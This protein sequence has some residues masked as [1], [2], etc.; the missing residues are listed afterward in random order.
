ME[1]RLLQGDWTKGPAGGYGTNETDWGAANNDLFGLKTGYL[2]TGWSWSRDSV[3]DTATVIFDIRKGVH[4]ALNPNSE[5]S[6][7]VNGR[8]MTADDVVYSIDRTCNWPI[9]AL[10][11]YRPELH[12]AQ[13][14]KTG[15]QQVSV[16]IKGTSNLLSVT[17]R[18][19]DYTFIEPKEVINKYGDMS[20]WQVAEATGPFMLTDYVAGS[21]INYDRNPN[22]WMK[23]PIGPGKGNQLPYLDRV[24]VLIVPDFS[25]LL[26]A[27]RTGKIDELDNQNLV[28]D[29][30]IQAKQQLPQIVEKIHASY[31]GRG[32]P[33][34]MR[35]DKPGL[36]WGP[37]DDPKALKVRQ[38]M[39]MAIDYQGILK[40]YYGGE[41]Q[42]VAWPQAYTKEYAGLYVGLDDPQFPNSARDLYGY[43]PDKAKQLLT[44]AGY[45][46]GFKCSVVL[47]QSEVDY[48]SMVK[49]YWSK[50]GIDLTFD[51][52]DPTTKLSITQSRS[53]PQMIT[54]TTGPVGGPTTNNQMWGPT[55][56]NASFIDDPFINKTIAK[57][58]DFL[59]D[60][61]DQAWA[62]YKQISIYVQ[63]KAY[64]IPNVIGNFYQF[65]WPWVK[66]YS[67]E[68]N[69][70]MDSYIWPM[71][72]WY[73]QDLKK[74]MGF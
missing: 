16:T 7:L 1:D 28:R 59:P 6:R 19:A 5:A 8:E 55:Y 15:P 13:I 9:A 48:Y 29:D 50:L 56:A 44:E 35:M 14:T 30:A 2:A 31:Q 66:N 12:G 63:D 10:G 17:G 64:V 18:L 3:N 47:L 61:E 37:Q 72:V 51:I 69:V 53:Y 74:T 71:F 23:D 54:Y 42:I 22:Y 43:H 58:A 57:V 36:P 11:M 60:H 46:N 25:T 49:D 41:G 45:P 20:Q 38:A 40:N 34:Y 21:S 33:L 32:T 4:W 68:Q 70:G 65:W 62:T 73:D 24:K 26:A 39:M 27:L 67:G 52:R